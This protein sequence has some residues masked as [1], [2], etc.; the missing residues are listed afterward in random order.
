[1]RNKHRFQRRMLAGVLVA[2][3]VAT[4]AVVAGLTGLVDISTLLLEQGVCAQTSDRSLDCDLGVLDAGES[5]TLQLLLSPNMAGVILNQVSIE[6]DVFDPNLHNNV[7][8]EETI[9][10]DPPPPIPVAD[11]VITKSDAPDPAIVGR[12]ITY[13]I[14][15]TNAGPDTA[16]N[17]IVTDSLPEGATAYQATPS[18]GLCSLQFS[19]LICDFGAIV[20]GGQ[21]TLAVQL[22][23]TVV[24]SIRNAAGVVSSAFD[25][26]AENN[27]VEEWTYVRALRADISVVKLDTPDPVRVGNLLTYDVVVTNNGPDA[28]R[29]RLVDLLQQSID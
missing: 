23:P 13:V 14:T 25:P 6:G 20:A 7:D 12:P 28:T 26:I 21:A 16:E 15:V 9:V 22:V 24:G 11:L 29:I 2:T 1:M 8:S 10:I 27:V 17:V 18:Q 3:G 5:T 19:T 4:S